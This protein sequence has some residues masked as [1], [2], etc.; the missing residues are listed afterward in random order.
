MSYPQPVQCLLT[1]GKHEQA[2]ATLTE[3]DPRSLEPSLHDI[4]RA[5]S[6]VTKVPLYDLTG[7]RR[8]RR[9]VRARFIYFYLARTLTSKSFPRIGY[10][11][12]RKDHST[13]MHGLHQVKIHFADYAEKIATVRAAVSS[14]G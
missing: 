11:C 7:P 10:Y 8:E 3:I 6:A 13:V 1:H 9:Y 14:H 4:L 5:V 2:I 12:G